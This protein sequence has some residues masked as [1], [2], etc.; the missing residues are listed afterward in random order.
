[1]KVQYK[2]DQ[3]VK[4]ESDVERLRGKPLMFIGLL[5]NA[6]CCHVC[7]E[8]INN[9]IDECSKPRSVT[10][11]D[12]IWIEFNE[13]EDWMI[14]S[15]NGRGIDPTKVVEIF[16]TLN[17]GSNMTREH[18]YTLGENG[19]G[20]LCISA[21][22]REAVIKSF[23][24]LHE[25]TVST[26]TF[27]E[28]KLI[29][30]T[31]TEEKEKHGLVVMYKPS[32]KIFGRDSHIDVDEMLEWIRSFRYRMSNKITINVKATRLDGSVVEETIKAVPFRKIIED[33]NEKLLFNVEALSF[34]GDVDE[35]FGGS[36]QNRTFHIDIAFGYVP[37][38]STPYI[39][40]FCNGAYTTDHGSHLDGVIQGITR[41]LK[42]AATEALSDKEK[43]KITIQPT[44]VQSGL[45]ISVNLMTNM[46]K[47]FVS[48]IKTKVDNQKFAKQL[49]NMVYEQLNEIINKSTLKLYVEMI[50]VNAKARIE[51]NLIRQ[52]T[53]KE[54]SGK[55]DRYSIEQLVPCAS[56]DKTKTELYICEGKS[57]KGALRIAR[58]PRYQAIFGVKGFTLN[59]YGKSIS[60]I[61]SN[62]EYKALIAAMGCGI[63]DSFNINK[64][65]YSKIIIATDADQDGF[66]I[67]SLIASFYI[68]FFP[69]IVRRGML[70]IADPPLYQIDYKPQEYVT[71]RKAYLDICEKIYNR[72]W[73]HID[74][75]GNNIKDSTLFR[76]AVEFNRLLRSADIYRLHKNV[77]FSIVA[78]T[79]KY[80]DDTG[81][82]GVL[83][84]KEFLEMVDKIKYVFRDDM[85]EFF[86]EKRG[87]Y[88][89]F[90]GVY[91]LKYMGLDFTYSTY[92][93]LAQLIEA[94][95]KIRPW[96]KI[97]I[98]DRKSGE[99]MTG[100]AEDP[101]KVIETVTMLMPK[102][103][104]RMKGLG[105]TDKEILAKTTL[106]P[107]TRTLIQINLSDDFTE[108]LSIIK[109]L[110]G[111][112]VEDLAS[113][114]QMIRNFDIDWDDIDN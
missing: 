30:Q 37:S 52:K 14:S 65:K 87:D 32:R 114:K 71:T 83:S 7:R 106:N 33:N 47:L 59:P 15:D 67:R 28:G 5:G 73:V 113:R 112:G 61:L 2:D 74:V 54:G 49:S 40:S 1:M 31:S 78:Q 62:E 80:I 27:R 20:T 4:F 8:A 94:T 60:Q 26:Y 6:G 45:T 75:N 48:Q 91:D 98:K 104:D 12:T 82:N 103:R 29:D 86:S 66:G 108:A 41:Y 13:K 69:E 110:R 76:D 22:A 3:M 96:E 58:D 84:K 55:W 92:Y 35:E 85:R 51:A 111:S 53:M 23:R 95:R 93:R 11:G 39:S 89:A 34:N 42:E 19:V 24:G 72:R 77:I 109:S 100:I 57:A 105:Q 18:G 36:I 88:I 70:F 17:M 43:E 79:A 38:E 44:D 25:K 101:L 102:I 107:E 10:P 21:L 64:L 16:T 46:M 9:H 99:V 63:G 68:I 97:Y 56:M 90:A 81:L 50:K